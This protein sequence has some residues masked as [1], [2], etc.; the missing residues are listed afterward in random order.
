MQES[1]AKTANQIPA[2]KINYRQFFLLKGI[3][4]RIPSRNG[5]QVKCQSNVISRLLAGMDHRKYRTC[6]CP[7]V[8]V[9]TEHSSQR[10]EKQLSGHVR[11]VSS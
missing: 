6:C 11:E 4:L 2:E 3:N 5:L 8:F 10:C 7:S 9:N 1:I